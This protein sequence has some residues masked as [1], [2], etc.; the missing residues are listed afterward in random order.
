VNEVELELHHMQRAETVGHEE[1]TPSTSK[2]NIIALAASILSL[3]IHQLFAMAVQ[4]SYELTL[5]VNFQGQLPDGILN[6]LSEI[7]K[8]TEATTP[9]TIRTPEASKAPA[10]AGSYKFLLGSDSSDED[11][12]MDETDA[13]SEDDSDSIINARAYWNSRTDTNEV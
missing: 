9:A 12:E 7:E 2:V 10:A 5:K 4:P 11:T 6:L 3:R 1:G 8:K 13:E